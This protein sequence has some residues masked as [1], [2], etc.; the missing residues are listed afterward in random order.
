MSN[1]VTLAN[2]RS[3]EA[4][5]HSRTRASRQNRLI[6]RGMIFFRGPSMPGPRVQQRRALG[7]QMFEGVVVV[8]HADEHQRR[9]DRGL[10][11]LIGRR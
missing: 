2:N 3:D 8:G 11:D 6:P 5:A 7:Q 1:G 10:T 4:A 9:T